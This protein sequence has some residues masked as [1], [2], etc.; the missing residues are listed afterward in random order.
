VVLGDGGQVCLPGF[1]KGTRTGGHG[2]HA[3]KAFSIAISISS[4]AAVALEKIYYVIDVAVDFPLISAR[5]EASGIV[6]TSKL[7][8][9]ERLAI[10][11][12]VVKVSF[13]TCHAV[14]VDVDVS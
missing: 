10:A 13:D 12:V 14:F 6:H 1:R 9:P 2:P 7:S 4:N 3:S 8:D 5:D 11:S